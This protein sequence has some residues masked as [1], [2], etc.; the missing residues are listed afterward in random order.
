MKHDRI[1]EFV[2]QAN[3]IQ[4]LNYIKRVVDFYKMLGG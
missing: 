3:N 2:I 4:L 1:E